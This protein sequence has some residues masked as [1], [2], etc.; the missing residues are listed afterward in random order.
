MENS[1]SECIAYVHLFIPDE[2]TI[3]YYKDNNLKSMIQ[4][5]TKKHMDC[6]QD[7]NLNPP[8]LLIYNK[9]KQ[10]LAYLL[11][12]FEETTEGDMFIGIDVLCTS[13]QERRKSLSTYLQMVLFL[14]VL[15]NNIKYIAADTNDTSY[16]SLKRFGF[17]RNKNTEYLELFN[18]TYTTYVETKNETFKNSVSKYFKIK[19]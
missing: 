16:A 11:F 18:Y 15:K 8:G 1:L 9:Q 19:K 5:F 13:S 10:L 4:S 3:V 7:M 17:K 14:F 12:N 6:Y 2:Y